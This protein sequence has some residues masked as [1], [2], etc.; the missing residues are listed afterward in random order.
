MVAGHGIT[1]GLRKRLFGWLPEVREASA[2]LVEALD[3]VTSFEAWDR[4]RG[5]QRLSRARARAA[6]EYTTHRLVREL[7][8][9]R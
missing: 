5:D 2:E 7:E 6:M 1:E 3:Q 8:G 9:D 4:L